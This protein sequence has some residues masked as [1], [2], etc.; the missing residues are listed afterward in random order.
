MKT[1]CFENSSAFVAAVWNPEKLVKN[2]LPK[3]TGQKYWAENFSAETLSQVQKIISAKHSPNFVIL[4]C[5]EALNYYEVI[6]Y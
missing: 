4:L 2:N 1:L 3:T 6:H 5:Y